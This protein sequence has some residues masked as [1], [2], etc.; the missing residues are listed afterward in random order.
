MNTSALGIMSGTS[1][2]GIDLAFCRFNYSGKWNYEIE[3]A[4][5]I[6]YS[7][8][9]T[10]RLINAS[11]LNAED[12]LLLHNEYGRYIG[13]LVNEFII[14]KSAPDL[15]CSHGHTIF[16]QPDK[17]FT[18]QIGNGASIA[19]STGITTISD[20]RTMDVALGGQ[21]APLV[22]IGDKLLFSDYA[23][24]INLGGFA[25]ISY[26]LNGRR[27]AYDICPVNIVLNDIAR[28]KNLSFDKDGELGASGNVNEQLLKA[29]NSL[30]YYRQNWPKSLGRE[31]VE[32]N[33][34]PLLANSDLS[35]EDQAAT[36]YEHISDQISQTIVPP[37]KVLFTGGGSMNKYLTERIRTKVKCKIIIPDEKLINFKEALIFAFL[38]VLSYKGQI[39]CLASVTGANADS[40]AGTIF[41]IRA[42]PVFT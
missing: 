37:E 31:W 25:N 29:L 42:D 20:F 27:I 36:Y 26:D 35:I 10:S 12:F 17:M 4:Q 7:S 34:V 40:I 21:G 22:P 15:I 24:C 6:P 38:G 32:K 39:N 16:H 9:W 23:Y 19:A 28:K 8:E 41:P 30:E 18:F 14:G 5:T 11:T 3:N 13:T 33:I 2:D 1:L